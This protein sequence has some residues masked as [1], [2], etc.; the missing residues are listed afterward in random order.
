MNASIHFGTVIETERLRLRPLCQSDLDAYA[1]MCSDPEV[2]RY[3]ATGR[4]LTR[5]EA[6]RNLAMMI[7][8]YHLRG[9]GL[10]ATELRASGELIGRVGCWNPEGW[11]GLEIG[12][13]LRRR[14]WHQGFATEAA[15]ACVAYAFDVLQVPRVISLIHPKNL[16]SMR[17]AERL[18]ERP[19]G[20]TEITGR[21]AVIYAIDADHWAKLSGML[22][23]RA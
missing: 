14:F 21:L 17:V 16:P 12:W 19:I 9:Y 13:M 15:R 23:S 1:E 4:T 20:M 3:I 5:A 8:H 7:G 22:S 10:W 2:M 18:G 11:P 6:W